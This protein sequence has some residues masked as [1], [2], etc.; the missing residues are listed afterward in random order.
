MDSRS[1]AKP[2][3][4]VNLEDT[5]ATKDNTWL[6][7]KT[8]PV[9]QCTI[10]ASDRMSPSRIRRERDKKKVRAKEQWASDRHRA[11]KNSLKEQVVG[12]E[13]K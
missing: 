5:N 4:T 9:C 6:Q 1:P 2:G 12:E 8:I 13:V 11:R 7:A 10:T 3:N